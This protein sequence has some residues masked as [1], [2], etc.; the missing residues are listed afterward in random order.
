MPRTALRQK[1]ERNRDSQTGNKK[2]F[3][4]TIGN[5]RKRYGADFAKGFA[6]SEK[7][8]DVI[9]KQPSLMTAVLQFEK[10]W[11]EKL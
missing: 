5:L 9:Q 7:L 2:Y 4:S 11:L 8:A 6:D 10:K 3:E 1:T